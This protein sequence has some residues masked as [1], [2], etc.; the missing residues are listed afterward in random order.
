MDFGR[1]AGHWRD[2]LAGALL[3]AG[4][5]GAAAWMWPRP[6]PPLAISTPTPRPTASP[7]ALLVVHV[8]GA[9]VNP[10]V[11]RLPSGSRAEQAVER[12]GG[13]TELLN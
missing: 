3:L 1:V 12:A 13:F 8:I 2:L 10:G 6:A 9:V 4:L 7:A 5:V 11:Y